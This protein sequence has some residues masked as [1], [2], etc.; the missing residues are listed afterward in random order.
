MGLVSCHKIGIILSICNLCRRQ[1]GTI[2]TELQY[3]LHDQNSSRDDK[4][5]DDGCSGRQGGGQVLC[6]KENGG[7]Q[8]ELHRE[9]DY[10]L[11]NLPYIVGQD[12]SVGIVI[13]YRRDGPGIESR[14]G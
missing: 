5:N 9:V 12:S 11:Y 3:T 8:V 6:L 2:N 7:A 4:I 1:F 10:N 13:G 14:W